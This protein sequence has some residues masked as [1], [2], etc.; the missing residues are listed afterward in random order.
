MELS[1]RQHTFIAHTKCCVPCFPINFNNIHNCSA[2]I[3]THKYRLWTHKYQCAKMLTI[4]KLLG[5]NTYTSRLG[6]ECSTLLVRYTYIICFSRN[7]IFFMTSSIFFP[8]SKQQII[9]KWSPIVYFIVY[10]RKHHKRTYI[11]YIK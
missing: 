4:E 7:F 6:M 8:D 5:F 2:Q 11:T 9:F 10:G 3:H 1:V